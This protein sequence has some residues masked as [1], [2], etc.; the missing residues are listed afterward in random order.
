MENEK[1]ENPNEKSTEWL[2]EVDEDGEVW[3]VAV[4]PTNW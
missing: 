3:G 4:M 2:Q 1:T